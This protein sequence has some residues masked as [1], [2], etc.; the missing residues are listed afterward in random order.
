MATLKEQDIVFTSK[1]ANGN[2][3]IQMPITRAANVEDLVNT[4]LP[5][6]GGNLSGN[7][8]VQDKNVVRSVNGTFAD[9]S[10]NVTLN[11]DAPVTSVQGKTGDIYLAMYTNPDPVRYSTAPSNGA[12]TT[13]TMPVD[14][15]TDIIVKAGVS[16]DEKYV[17]GSN[18]DP[19]YYVTVV[20][21]NTRMW[22]KV[23]GTYL[24]ADTTVSKQS[25]THTTSGLY[26]H[27]GDV[28]SAYTYRSASG[29]YD[30]A[31]SFTIS[32]NASSIVAS[33][34]E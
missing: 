21:G 10:G 19:S 26:L 14:G 32:V 28:I 16:K 30:E 5:L 31:H 9:T 17:A 12:T 24:Y 25:Q 8:T 2:P 3:V 27:K 6:S 29:W 18:D 7:L 15:Y 1:D 33:T 22:V 13:Y 34:I 4:C 11:I 23:N 20:Q